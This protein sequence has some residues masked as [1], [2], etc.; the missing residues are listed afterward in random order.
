[1]RVHLHARAV[2]RHFCIARAFTCPIVWK[3]VYKITNVFTRAFA[4]LYCWPG[5]SQHSL[6]M[7]AGGKDILTCTAAAMVP[8]FVNVSLQLRSLADWRPTVLGPRYKLCLQRYNRLAPIVRP[9]VS[10]QRHVLVAPRER[11]KR[12]LII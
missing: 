8:P 3:C 4:C 10:S 5:R 6:K 12:D 11:P 1:M 2:G 7:R 9:P